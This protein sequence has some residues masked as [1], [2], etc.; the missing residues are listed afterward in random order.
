MRARERQISIL[1]RNLSLDAR[2]ALQQEDS[3]IET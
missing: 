1:P 3:G 2:L